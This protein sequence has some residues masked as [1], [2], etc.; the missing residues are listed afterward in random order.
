MSMQLMCFKD[1]S[2]GQKILVLCE[3]EID[4]K[5]LLFSRYQRH[6]FL[7]VEV[8][9]KFHRGLFGTPLPQNVN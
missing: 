3:S 8:L 5:S 7:L 9:P 4:G 1:I 2:T 6:D